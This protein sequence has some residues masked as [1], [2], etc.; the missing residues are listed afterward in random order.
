MKILTRLNCQLLQRSIA[1]HGLKKSPPHTIVSQNGGATQWLFDLRE[2]FLRPAELKLFGDIFWDLFKECYPFQVGGQETAAIPLIAAIMLKGQQ[3][4]KPVNGFIIRKNR[5]PYGLQK[6]IEG[7]LNDSKIILVDDLVN[8]G[9]TLLNQIRVLEEVDKKPDTVFTV[10]RYRERECYR[11]LYD[12]SIKLFSLFSLDNFGVS[13]ASRQRAEVPREQFKPVWTFK[14]P[15]PNFFYRV[16]KSSPYIDTVKIYFGTDDGHMWALDQ[17]DG[18]VIWK[19]RVG[20]HANGK[21]IFSSPAIFDGILYFG[22]YDGCV[23]ALDAATGALIWQN[24]DA[25]WVGSSPAIAGDLG[26][27][28]IGLEFAL[29]QRRGGIVALDLKTGVKKWEHYHMAGYTHSSPRYIEEKNSVVI[30][31]NDGRVYA[32]EAQTGVLSWEIKTGDAVKASFAYDVSRN[33][34]CFGSFDK[35]IYAVDLHSGAIA[36]QIP[37][38]G[39]IFS[40]PAVSSN[41]LYCGSSDKSLYAISLDTGRITGKFHAGGRIFSTP[42][43]VDGSIYF[44]ATDGKMY[45]L[46]EESGKL[47]GLYQVTERITNSILFNPTSK[48]FFL[49]TYAN[50][51]YCLIKVD[52]P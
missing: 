30:G 28:F 23:Y 47:V 24:G 27:L 6:K 40:T 3:V 41:V 46:L 15:Q 35:N 11:F 4:G 20:P 14:A 37:T 7:V 13:L 8:S 31:N 36:F 45:E 10:I 42:L 51:L 32:F 2:V 25:D 19:F 16:P 50:E 22:A 49:T 5:K 18:S 26:M 44:G 17:G 33:L 29:P 43:I 39:I 48:R 9:Q 12:R 21:S 1:Q 52:L 38:E 34:V